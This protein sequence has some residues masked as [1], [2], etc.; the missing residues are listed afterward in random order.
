ML[1]WVAMNRKDAAAAEREFRLSLKSD[2]NAAQVCVW[3]GNLLR[4]RKTPEAMSQA[5]FF[6][7]RVANIEDPARAEYEKFVRKLYVGYH[8]DEAG[9]E[10]LMAAAKAG[11]FPP[12][13]FLIQS[14]A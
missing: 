12:E 6:Y 3:L 1:G 5:L 7:A 8:G 11:A 10:G 4:A 2:A 9:L 14:A 13:R